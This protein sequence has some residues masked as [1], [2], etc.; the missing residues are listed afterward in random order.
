MSSPTIRQGDVALVDVN[1]VG[2]A[3]ERVLVLAPTGRD[4]V[5]ACAFL[6]RAGVRARTCHD[7]PTLCHELQ[8]ASGAALISEEAFAGDALAQLAQALAHQPPWSDL[9][10]LV[11]GDARAE[12]GGHRAKILDTIANVTWIQRPAHTAALMS[13]VQSALRAR[14]RQYQL[15]EHLAEREAREHAARSAARLEQTLRAQVSAARDDLERVLICIRDEL[16]IVDRSWRV[17]YVNDQANAGTGLRKED[18][19]GK[20]LWEL[21]SDMVGGKFYHEA[22]RAMSER[23]ARQFDYYHPRL[24]CWFEYRLYP[25]PQ[26]LLILKNDVTERKQGDER[27]A[28]L[29]A[30]VESAGDAIISQTPDGIITSWNA[31]AQRMYGH[32]ADDVIGRSSGVLVPPEHADAIEAAYARARAGGEVE[33]IQT[34]RVRQ[35]GQRVPVAIRV[36]PIKNAEGSVTGISTIEIATTH[37]DMVAAARCEDQDRWRRFADFS[38]DALLVHV[39]D[40][41]VYANP[42]ALMYCGTDDVAQIL[43]RS[44]L[45]FCHLDDR[46]LV[47][48]RIEHI[49]ATGQTVPVVQ[50]RWVRLDGSVIDVE[51]WSM[52]LLWDDHNGIQMVMHDITERMRAENALRASEVRERDHA[53]ALQAIMEVVPAAVFI[54]DDP[55]CRRITGNRAGYGLLRLAEGS[56]VSLSAPSGDRPT[57]YRVIRD[58]TE[59][60]VHELPIQ[61]AASGIEMRDLEEDVVFADGSTVNLYG[62]AVPLYDEHGRPRGAVAAFV[63]ITAR[64]RAEQALREAAARYRYIFE[65]AR[66]GICELDFTAVENAVDELRAQGVTD[67][68]AHFLEHA[69]LVQRLAEQVMV[70]DVNAEAVALW[71]A[72]SREQLIGPMLDMPIR[73]TNL[74]FQQCFTALAEGKTGIEVEMSIA[75]RRKNQR[76]LLCNFAFPHD[77][78]HV[79]GVLVSAVDITERRSILESLQKS[80]AALAKAQAIA[81]VGSWEWDVVNNTIAWSDEMYRIFGLVPQTERLVYPAFVD[82]LVHPSCRAP[83]HDALRAALERGEPFDMELT[84]ILPDGRE[85]SV[86]LSADI[87]RDSHDRLICIVGTAQDI[88]RRK[89][90]EDALRV[91]ESRFRTALKSAPI[92]MFHQDRQL[93]YTWAHDPVGISAEQAVGKRD[94][95]FLP[96]AAQAEALT[97]FKQSVLETGQPA[98]GRFE[99]QI[100]ERTRQFDIMC[101]PARNGDG[102]VVG[103]TCAAVDI[104]DD[105]NLQA[106]LRR[107][108]EQLARMD[109]RKNEFMAMLAHELRN[110]LAP[111]H[112]AVHVLKIQPDPP[113]AKHV[114]WALDVIGR[115]V[116]HIMRLVDDLLDI[117]R[118]THGRIQLQRRLTDVGDVLAEAVETA[119]PLFEGRRHRISYT[120]PPVRL[121]T[122][123]DPTRLAQIVC[124]LLSNAA[125]YTPPGGNISLA[126]RAENQ[127]V[128]ITVRDDG[129]GIPAEALPHIFDLFSQ[130]RTADHVQGG[131][132]L[133]LSLVHRLVELHGGRV[134]VHSD[135]RGHGS[136]FNVYLPMSQEPGMAPAQNV[137]HPVEAGP[138]VRIL[139]VDDNK[140]VAQSFAVLLGIMGH[141]VQTVGDGAAALEAAAS[142]RPDLAFIDIGLP[143]IDG[144]ELGRRLRADYPTGT[145]RL[146]ALTGYG[147]DEVRARA[148]ASGFDAHVVKPGDVETLEALLATV[149]R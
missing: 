136:E 19:L 28:R 60:P 24:E 68:A 4:A 138:R 134:T 52:P 54:S 58:G 95:D 108:A 41:I 132:G 100:Q 26:G 6:V 55:D 75:T 33:R 85:R 45:D 143:D 67:I 66:V 70:R 5:L 113:D 7:M 119:R 84:V 53:A 29:A 74:V 69:H 27:S 2:N 61:K 149:P 82:R 87:V 64:R 137:Q 88:T 18:I 80:E 43:G 141:T 21:F 128:V 1:D 103:I 117:A 81:H 122:H 36:S 135:G 112:N 50:H 65:G 72:E 37:A 47:E 15:R 9:P 116:L 123:A 120:P 140:D 56:N 3:E 89:R 105:V 147:H 110:P 62:N 90:I 22:Q 101:D 114:R 46:S 59:L 125:R 31:G 93:V 73:A 102:Q 35:D 98:R 142:F 12:V 77:R 34:E 118:I 16:V 57:H 11:L 131:L 20:S 23:V 115:Q 39:A 104:T 148:Q 42:A 94:A 96:N 38:P 121:Q 106:Q 71:E 99:I 51:T 92:V 146:I 44:P 78:H 13:V 30:I 139:V 97:R 25:Q 144:Y 86:Q 109:Q 133:G 79:R 83:L 107:Q 17:T 130:V 14:R 111:I 127:E 76:R 124:N 32:A 40:R 8:A 10:V 91:N 49:R 129:I 126:A 48:E 145:L 63:D